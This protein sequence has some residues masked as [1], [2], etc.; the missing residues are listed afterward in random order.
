MVLHWGLRQG[1]CAGGSLGMRFCRFVEI[2]RG[3]V[4]TQQPQRTEP[5]QCVGGQPWAYPGTLQ[6]QMQPLLCAAGLVGPA[7]GAAAGPGGWFIGVA[8]MPVCGNFQEEESLL[9]NHSAQSPASVWVGSPGHA[10]GHCKRSNA[11]S[12]VCSRCGGACTGGCGRA[13]QVVC[14]G[15]G[16]VAFLS[17]L[18][19]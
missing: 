6:G 12:A 1:C 4:I 5:C 10:M 16:F 11:A 7:L 13:V 3:G 9:G 2:P 15:C 19:E 14:G 17:F 8:V 18:F